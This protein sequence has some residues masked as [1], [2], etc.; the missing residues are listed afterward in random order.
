MPDKALLLCQLTNSLQPVKRA[1]QRAVSEAIADYDISMSLAMLM[2]LVYR[3]PDGI[4][5]KLLAE[6]LGINPGALVRLLDQA[7]QEQWLERCEVA[8]DRRVK[9]LHVLPKGAELAEKLV[10]VADHLRQE[11]MADV[12]EEDIECATRVLRQFENNATE[13]VQQCKYDK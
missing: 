4:T 5:Q 2:V 10:K 11:L 3:H 9:T 13:Y 6:E 12:P 1:W 7:A 8:G